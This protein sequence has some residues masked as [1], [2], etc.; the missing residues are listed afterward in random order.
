MALSPA[1]EIA[2]TY[3][4]VHNGTNYAWSKGV[5]ICAA[6]G[7]DGLNQ[8]NYPAA[9]ANAIAVASTDSADAKSSFSNYGTWVSLAAP[10]SGIYSTLPN[11][12]NTISTQNYGNLSS[13]GSAA[14]A[15]V[16][17]EWGTSPG[18]FTASSAP[19]SANTTGAFGAN[20][21]GLVPSTR[22]YFRAK[23]DGHGTSFGTEKSF[24]TPVHCRPRCRLPGVV[25][26][27]SMSHR[28][29]TSP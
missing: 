17:F 10:G 24:L 28:R 4:N 1:T 13:F 23:A 11:H 21:G 6:A 20:L 9:Y 5:V 19:V 22:Y 12:A 29:P 7:N 26:A 18:N 27:A 14:S 2:I 3:H 16:S 8:F 15:N 25:V